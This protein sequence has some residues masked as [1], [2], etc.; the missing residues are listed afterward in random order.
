MNQKLCS[1]TE[2]EELEQEVKGEK[3]CD[4]PARAKK[5]SKWHPVGHPKH[6]NV[7]VKTKHGIATQPPSSLEVVGNIPPEATMC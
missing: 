3:Q 1:T 5:Q 4:R 7:L 6:E 2:K